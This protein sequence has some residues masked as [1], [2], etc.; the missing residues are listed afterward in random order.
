MKQL[1]SLILI[2]VLTFF[3]CQK[4]VDINNVQIT[5]ISGDERLDFDEYLKGI[6]GSFLMSIIL[7]DEKPYFLHEGELFSGQIVH[8][9]LDGT[10]LKN[11]SVQNGLLDG[12]N[13]EFNKD[14]KL[15]VK[16]NFSDG[17]GNG[18]FEVYHVNGQLFEEGSLNNNK[19][20]G[21]YKSYF[22]NGTIQSKGSYDKNQR[23]GVWNFFNENESLIKRETYESG[24]KHGK[25]EHFENEVLVR[26]ENYHNDELHGVVN[27]YDQSGELLQEQ[28]YEKG[29]RVDLRRISIVG[30]DD[31]RFVVEK[32]QSGVNTSG[33]SR[34]MNIV[35]SIEVLANQE[36]SIEMTTKS[37]LP[38]SAIS[39][40][41]V[42]LAKDSNINQFA[43][44]SLTAR[45]NDYISPDFESSIIAHTKMLGDAE[46]DTIN[47]VAPEE[48]GEYDILCTFPGHYAGGMVAK[49]IVK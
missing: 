5:D 30:T 4:Q 22:E 20:E 46:T 18:R 8:K 9:L 25:V 32:E 27:I 44:S 36:F 19:I 6:N 23:V 37:V 26:E 38:P 28:V 39:H 13:Q 17:Y 48:S 43:R 34:N 21:E 35:K 42:I 47:V 29:I 24:V 14:G 2:L 1:N 7:T 41:L 3:G 16:V 49:L 11:Y 40:N 45:D 33:K 10:L 15:S 31:L 12:L